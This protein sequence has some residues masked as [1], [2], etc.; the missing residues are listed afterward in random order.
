M[1]LLLSALLN[2][3]H[4]LLPWR[5]LFLHKTFPFSSTNLGKQYLINK[6]YKELQ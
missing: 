2:Q 4:I 6:V 5:I 3:V 1:I